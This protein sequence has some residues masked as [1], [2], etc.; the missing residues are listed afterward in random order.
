MPHPEMKTPNFFIVGAAKAGTTSLY[1]YLAQ[2]PEIY[3]SPLKEPTYFALEV[4]PENFEAARQ[5]NVRNQIEAVKQSLHSDANAAPVHGIVAEWEDYCL[6]YQGAQQEKALGEASISYLWSPSARLPHARI[7]MVLRHPAERAF[8]HYLNY[9]SFGVIDHTFAQ[10]IRL[11]LGAAPSH[12]P[13][14]P[15]LDFGCYEP[16]VRRYLD[17]FPKEQI[18]IWTYEETTENPRLFH[19]Q[20]MSFLGVAASFVPDT[21]TRHNKLHVSTAHRLTQAV[22]RPQIM[23]RLAKSTPRSVKDTLKNALPFRK[24][25]MQMRRQDREF[26]VDYYRDDVHKLEHLLQRDLSAWLK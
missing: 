14:Y 11:C 21:S 15:F 22:M 6:L 18:G 1:R 3:M 24:R 10:Q 19:Q 26:L 4:R 5:A 13:Y 25:S 23:R 17:H 8:S 16:Q 12:G 9:V 7:V 2:H 20:V